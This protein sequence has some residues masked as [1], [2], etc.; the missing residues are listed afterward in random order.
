MGTPPPPVTPPSFFAGLKATAALYQTDDHWKAWQFVNTNPFDSVF[1]FSGG[2][3]AADP[4]GQWYVDPVQVL[5]PPP[6]P[7]GAPPTAT[8]PK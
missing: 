6:P 1:T 5:I 2:I 8:S 4:Q 7:R 3:G